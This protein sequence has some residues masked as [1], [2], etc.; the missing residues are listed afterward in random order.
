MNVVI[1]YKYS[2]FVKF[3]FIKFVDAIILGVNNSDFY[4]KVLWEDR[5]FYGFFLRVWVYYLVVVGI[6]GFFEKRFREINRVIYYNFGNNFFY[7]FR[8]R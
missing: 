2:F 6:I 1:Y 4:I 3:V 5:D 7:G 8:I